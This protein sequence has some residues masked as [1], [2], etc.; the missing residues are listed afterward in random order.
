MRL[1]GDARV[2]CLGPCR[3]LRR[4]GGLRPGLGLG[5]WEAFVR[6][7]TSIVLEAF[8]LGLVVGYDL[9]ALVEIV[10]ELKQCKIKN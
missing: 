8:V 4:A 6:A 1:S 10:E 3:G 5:V 9:V 2:P 7:T